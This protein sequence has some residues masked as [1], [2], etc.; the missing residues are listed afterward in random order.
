MT[1]AEKRLWWHLRHTLALDGTHF[2]RQVAIGRYV[3][4]F[5]C[6]QTRLILEVDGDQ[7]GRERGM[8]WDEDRTRQLETLGFRVLRF[9]NRDVMTSTTVVLDT[10]LA[11]CATAPPT[12]DPS[13][14]GGGERALSGDGR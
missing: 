9:S 8:R 7:H 11:A 4:D 1:E 14:R 13:P 6:L 10:I 12:P 5:C 3:V 2:R